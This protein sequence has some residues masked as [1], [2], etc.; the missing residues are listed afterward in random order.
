MK[1]ARVIVQSKINRNDGNCII[2]IID[3]DNGG[4]ICEIPITY[5]DF[6]D[7]TLKEQYAVGANASFCDWYKI[8]KRRVVDTMK[9]EMPEHHY[10]HRDKVAADVARMNCPKGWA[11]LLKEDSRKQFVYEYNFPKVF[12]TTSICRYATEAE[13]EQEEQDVYQNSEKEAAEKDC[14]HQEVA[15]V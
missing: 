12:A 13:L 2:G 7:L 3:E 10:H 14:D 9:F 11:V 15:L 5:G 1:H 4:I 6:V 8:G